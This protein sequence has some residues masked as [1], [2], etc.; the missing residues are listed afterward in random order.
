MPPL[1]VVDAF[2]DRPFAGNPAAVCVLEGRWPSDEWLQNL[3][4]E[5]NLSETAFLIRRGESEFDL[6]W[7][8]PKIEVAL[9]GHATLASAHALWENGHAPRTMLGF[10]TRSGPLIATPLLSGEIELDFPARPA[11]A[12][13]PPRGFFDAL[14]VVSVWVG[15]NR[16]DYLVEVGSER[17]VRELRPD[18]RKLAGVECR[19]V[20]VSARSDDARFDFV[21]RFFAPAAG[22]DE[23]PVTGSAHCCLSEHWGEKL[24]KT[25]L[26]A[27]QASSR[28]GVVRVTRRG[29]RVGL[30]GRAVTISRGE[31]KIK[32]E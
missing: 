2:T 8:T 23:D 5:M 16:D 3:G 30:A 20:I 25:E 29:P 22:I 32:P 13:E 9:C 7:F 11:T 31:L 10:A 1:Y 28:G 26:V 19:G 4:R 27:Y 17:E 24:G 12:C 15:S 14:G 18:F 21:S 6:R